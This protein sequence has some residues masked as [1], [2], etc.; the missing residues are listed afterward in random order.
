MYI[1]RHMEATLLKM[2]KMFPALFIAGPRQVGKTTLLRE[3]KPNV[4]YVTMDDPLVLQSALEQTRTFF[5]I[6]TPPVMIDEIQ[7]APGLFPYVKM[8]ADERREKGMFYMTGSQQFKMMK[9]VSESLAGRIGILTLL[10]LSLREMSGDPFR[11]PFLPTEGYLLKRRESARPIEYHDIWKIIHTGSMPEFYAD[12]M[13]WNFYFSAYAKTYL[14]R[15]VRDLAQV[16]DQGKFLRFMTAIAANIGNLLNLSSVARDVGVSA[17]TVD[18]W[19]SILETSSIIY[20][21]KPYHNN[22]MKR[23]VKTAKVY[24]MDTGLAAYLTRWTTP[25]VL[26]NGAMAGAFFE[27][28]V[29]VEILK[30]YYNAGLEAPL[31][32]YRD[33]DQREIDL[34]IEREGA[35]H[36]IE[37]KKHADPRKGDT[38]SFCVLDKIPNMKRGTGA[39]L[40]LYDQVVPLSESD[41]VVPIHYV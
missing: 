29:V 11:E 38:D 31:F 9:N 3:I 7:Y 19:L 15:D 14:E 18:R 17:P 36:P 2:E 35:L 27:N 5:R 24:F 6:H 20:L 30:S 10:G 25:E 37:I 41:F 23:M 40:C 26:A 21:L 16:G 32:F 22:R 33:R 28:F 12:E 4:N 13:D 34:L 1:P 39:V 8:L